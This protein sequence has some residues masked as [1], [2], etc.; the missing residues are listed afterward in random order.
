MSKKKIKDL[1]LEEIKIICNENHC[2]L[3]D[4]PH[5]PLETICGSFGCIT[6]KDLEREIKIENE[7]N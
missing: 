5:C 6:N 3:S 1:T 2:L 4:Y 7:N